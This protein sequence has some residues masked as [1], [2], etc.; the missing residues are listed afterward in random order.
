MDRS[1]TLTRLWHYKMFSKHLWTMILR[2][3]TSPTLNP[4]LRARDALLSRGNCKSGYVGFLPF[5]QRNAIARLHF[6]SL[7]CPSTSQFGWRRN[8]TFQQVRDV[9]SPQYSLDAEESTRITCIAPSSSSWICSL[10]LP[11]V[12]TDRISELE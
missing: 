9:G 11:E 3:T 8:N 7:H 12:W 5:P 10:V 2:S 4:T 1:R 6:C